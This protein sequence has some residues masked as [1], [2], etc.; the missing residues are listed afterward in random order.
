MEPPDAV[1]PQISVLPPRLS[2][3]SAL[4][5]SRFPLAPDV[6]CSGRR[7]SVT[8]SPDLVVGHIDH[9]DPEVAV[10]PGDLDP[11]LGA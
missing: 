10:K 1:W 5:A 11:H 9:R 7:T 4:W 3:K 2:E 6:R 8:A